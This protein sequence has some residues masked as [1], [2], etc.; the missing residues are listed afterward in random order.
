MTQSLADMRREYT[1]D[2]LSEA[3]APSD[4]F[5]LFRQWFDDAVKT[6]R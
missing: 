4:P 2:G 3:N 1:R 6:E 5:S